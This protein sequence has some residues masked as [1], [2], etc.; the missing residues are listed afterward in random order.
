[1]ARKYSFAIERRGPA[2]GE[3]AFGLIRDAEAWAR[4]AGPPITYSAWKEDGSLDDSVV[5]RTRLVGNRRF[6]AAEVIT[7]DESPHTH[8]YRIPAT[9][10]VRDYSSVVTF[11]EDRSGEL[12]VRWSGEF[13]ERIPGT[14]Y[15]W[16][17]FLRRLLG[18]FA[19]RLIAH[20]RAEG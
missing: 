19:E 9:F 20:A 4:W 5:G 1:M 13:T 8:G 3:K 6:P 10:P 12:T 16:R 2:S 18:R 15:L 11:T 7:I 14:G 17:G